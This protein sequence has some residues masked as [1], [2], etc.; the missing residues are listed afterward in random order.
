MGIQLAP[1]LT[2]LRPLFYPARPAALLLARGPQTRAGPGRASGSDTYRASDRGARRWSRTRRPSASRSPKRMMRTTSS[3]RDWSGGTAPGEGDLR[4][5]RAVHHGLAR[6]GVTRHALLVGGLQEGDA[7]LVPATGLAHLRGRRDSRLGARHPAAPHELLAARVAGVHRA[8]PVDG[9]RLRFMF[10][11]RAGV[12]SRGDPR[13]YK[14]CEVRLDPGG[15]KG[16]LRGLHGPELFLLHG[17]LDRG[18]S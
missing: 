9:A 5:P 7:R 4:V 3:T 16:L 17:D 18:V 1:D 10:L 14:L 2:V 13:A 12:F 15:V 6:G 11:G 8:H